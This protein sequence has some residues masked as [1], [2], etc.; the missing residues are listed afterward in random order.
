MRNRR[1]RVYFLALFLAAELFVWV[2]PYGAR[3]YFRKIA[4][5]PPRVSVFLPGH[6]P[7]FK[8]TREFSVLKKWSFARPASVALWEEKI[9]K[10]KTVYQA[11]ASDGGGYLSAASRAAS[12]GLYKKIKYEVT[13][14]LYLAWDWKAAEFPKKERPGKLADR[15][16][17]DFAARVYVIF[18]G[19]PFFNSHVIEYLWDESLP[20]GTVASSPFSNGIKLFVIQ[21]GR[22]GNEGGGWVHE[23]RNLY[24]DYTALFEAKP[25]RPMEAIAIMS[26]SDNTHSSSAAFFKNIEI[27]S[28]KTDS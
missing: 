12:S 11:V 23:E 1:L 10:G 26:D 17:D 5:P 19:T 7:V 4:S 9:F 2:A 8:K 16:Q 28:K 15:A 3:V 18:S 14:H 27:K 13:P 24:E 21:S 25:D 6:A 22:A 20:K